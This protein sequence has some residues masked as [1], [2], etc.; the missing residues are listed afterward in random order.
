MQ[1]TPIIILDGIKFD[2]DFISTLLTCGN[3]L[4]VENEDVN[5]F[6]DNV[7]L[8][9][10]CRHLGTE[11]TVTANHVHSSSVGLTPH[12]HLP[13]DFTSAF[14]LTDNDSAIILDPDGEA[15]RIEPRVG[16]F[17]IFPA[18]LIHAVEQ[19]EHPS[20]RLALIT[21]YAF[22]SAEK[23]IEDVVEL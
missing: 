18:S 9:V 17:V 12:D 5:A 3:K 19:S 16:R 23:D 8:P 14:Y 22:I 13:N 6:V 15:L 1:K 20:F 21:N 2:E 7:L 10:T 11:V 4:Y